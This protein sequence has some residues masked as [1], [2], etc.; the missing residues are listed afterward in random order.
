[1]ASAE[2]SHPAQDGIDAEAELERLSKLD[3][4]ERLQELELLI[5]ELERRLDTAQPVDPSTGSQ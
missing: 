2:E 1:M 3:P 5:A 4:K